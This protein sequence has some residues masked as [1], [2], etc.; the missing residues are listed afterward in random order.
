ML[1]DPKDHVHPVPNFMNSKDHILTASRS[2]LDEDVTHDT[3]VAVVKSSKSTETTPAYFFYPLS[4]FRSKAKGVCLTLQLYAPNSKHKRRLWWQASRVASAEIEIPS[5]LSSVLSSSENSN[6]VYW[7]LNDRDIA[8]SD[9]ESVAYKIFGVMRWKSPAMK[10]LTEDI[11]AQLHSLRNF[12][13]LAPVKGI[14]PGLL[15]S[16]LSEELRQEL[17]KEVKSEPPSDYKAAVNKMGID[18]LHLREQNKIL[19]RDNKR[20]EEYLLQLE[21]SVI[22]SS[23]D[24]AALSVLTKADLIHKILEQSKRLQAEVAA[25]KLCHDKVKALQNSLIEKN[26]IEARF[27]EVQQAHSAQQKLVRDLQLKYEKYRK[28]SDICKQQEDVIFQLESLFEQ[29]AQ[30]GQV[31]EAIA[32]L[33]KENARL[34]RNLRQSQEPSA[35]PHQSSHSQEATI[36]ALRADL[37]KLRGK[38][39]DLEAQLED[40]RRRQSRGLHEQTKAFEANQK[41]KIAAAKERTLLREL[42]ENAKLWAQEKARYEVQLAEYQTRVQSLEEELINCRD[43]A[44]TRGQRSRAAYAKGG[45]SDRHPQVQ[46]RASQLTRNPWQQRTS[47]EQRLPLLRSVS[48]ELGRDSR[49][50]FRTQPPSLYDDS[51]DTRLSF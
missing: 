46:T 6:G 1:L 25:R 15:T 32:V 33:S 37:Q 35:S 10:F 27:V 40:S 26:E 5:T 7:E 47:E 36:N 13:D 22:L 41:V 12:K 45:D 44:A 8:Q 9:S 4:F 43:K 24:Q 23:S 31:R 50:S 16:I 39:S 2:S 18:I 29:S 49:N 30:E 21:S 11:G 51:L 19:R 42:E 28:C 14:Q 48:Q 3:S 20:L 38:C 34:R 17:E